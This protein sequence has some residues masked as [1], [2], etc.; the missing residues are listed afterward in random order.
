MLQRYWAILKNYLHV[1]FGEMNYRPPAWSTRFAR[2]FGQTRMGLWLKS[3]CE[4]IKT[5]PRLSARYGAIGLVIAAILGYGVYRGV[6][7]YQSRPKPDY[8]KVTLQ[9]PGNYDLENK[10]SLPL[11]I[12]FSQS[13][14]PLDSVDKSPAEHIELSPKVEGK[15]RWVSDRQIEFTPASTDDPKSHWVAG[16]KY[17]VTLKKKLVAKHILLE[18]FDY[19]F[20]A[21]EMKAY[22]NKQEFYQ[23][24]RDPKIKRALVNFSYNYPL[25]TEDFKKR[26]TMT[27]QTKDASVLGASAK[28]V[29]F[30][31]TFNKYQ[32]EAYLQSDPIAIPKEDSEV[33]VVVEKGVRDFRGG[34]PT[35]EKLSSIV[36]IPGMFNYFRFE[37]PQITFARNERYE[38]EQ[39]LVLNSKADIASENVAKVLE[40]FVLPRN[41]PSDKDKKRRH[42]FRST[43]E[44]TPEVRGLMKPLAFTLIPTETPT[45]T[46]HSFKTNAAAGQ[47]IYLKI[48]K[49][50]KSF[51]GYELAQDFEAVVNVPSYP[52]ELLIMSQGSLLS[53]SG[54]KKIPLLSRNVSKVDFKVSRILPDQLNQLIVQVYPSSNDFSHP[55]FGYFSDD[56]L[57]EK[58]TETREI[59]IDKPMAT[60]YFSFDLQSYLNRGSQAGRR[61][62]FYLSA[63]EHKGS[64]RDERLILLTDL[65][66]VVKET[67]NNTNDVFV[68]NIHSGHAVAG[69]SVE[70]LGANGIPVMEAR[71][72]ADGRASFPDLRDFKNEKRPIAF[73]V[74]N[75]SDYSFLPYQMASRQLNFSNF[76]TG[77]IYESGQSGTLN[78]FLFSDRGIYRPGDTVNFGM[79]VRG[80]NWKNTFKDVPVTWSVTDARGTEILREKIK[81]NSSD[82]MALKFDTKDFSPTGT[83]DV[84]VFITKKNEAD[85]QIGSLNVRVEEFLPDRMRISTHL[86]QERLDGWVNPKDLKARVNLQNLF[87]TPAENRLVKATLDLSTSSPGFRS[88]R[89]YSFGELN[90]ENKNFSEPLEGLKTDAKGN[91]EFDLN[92]QRFDAVM[93]RLKFEAEGFEAEGGRGVSATAGALVSPLPYLIGYRR[94]SDLTYLNKNSKHAIHLIA[95]NPELKKIAIDDVKLE[96]IERRYVSSLTKQYDGTYKYQS[97]VKE[98]PVETKPLKITAGG[99]DFELPTDKAGD[100]T[101]SLKN[102]EGVVLNKI[103]FTVT[104]EGNLSRSLEKNAELG[105]VLNKKDYKPGEEI[106]MQIKAPYSG[107]GLITIERDR[108]FTHKWFKTSTSATV[109]RIRIPEGVEGN[110]FVN[111]TFLRAIDSKEIFMSPLSYAVQPFS[112][113]LDSHRVN[114][115]LETKDLVKPGNKLR[116]TYSADKPTKIIVYGVNEGILQV[117]GYKLPDPLTY[118][119]QRR[120]LQVKTFQLL[121]LLLPEYSVLQSLSAPGGDSYGAM[122]AENLNPFKRKTD[123]PVVFW[124]GVVNAGPEARHYD[125]EVPDYFNG[126]I[127]VMAVAANNAIFGSTDKQV[128]VRGDFILSPNVPAFV[129]PGDEFEV[130]TGISNQAEKSGPDAKIKIE[131]VKSE[132]FEVLGENVQTAAVAEGHEGSVKFRLKAKTKLGS[133]KVLLRASLG[134]KSAKAQVEFS[135]RPATPYIS[136]MVAG[137]AEKSSFDIKVERQLL[138]EFRK[139]QAGLSPVPA[140]LIPSLKTFLDDFNYACTEQA[141]SKAMPYV[142]LKARPEFKVDVKTAADSFAS[143]ITLLRTRQTGNGGFGLYLPDQDSIEASLYALHLFLEAKERGFSV[144]EDMLEKA[145]TFA[146]ST[147]VRNTKTIFDI[148]QFAY[149]VYLRARAGRVPGSDVSFIH[150]ALEKNFKDVWKSD[151]AAAYLAATYK[152]VK[153]DDQGAKVFSG[154]SVGED[155][156]PNYGYFYDSL[157]RDTTV[158]YL[159]ARHFPEQ[160]KKFVTNEA[161]AKVLRPLVRGQY[162][163]YSAAHALLT[164]DQLVRNA[165]QAEILNQI[166][167][168]EVQAGGKRVALTMPNLLTPADFSGDAEKIA[169][170]ASSSTPMF[171]VHLQNG[172]D[173]ELPKTEL[174]KNMEITRE[175]LDGKGNVVNKAKV[176]EELT[177]RLRVRAL[178][179]RTYDNIVLVDLLPG[180]F[181]PVL[182]KIAMGGSSEPE[183]APESYTPEPES[184]FFEEPEAPP[185]EEGAMNLLDLILPRAW[186][187]DAVKAALNDLSPHY[188]D[189]REDRMVVYGSISAEAR[190]FRYKI[191]AVAQGQFVVPPPF[192]ESMYDK[193]LMYRGL[194]PSFTIEAP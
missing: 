145:L 117:A 69:A 3:R 154:L 55:N 60:Q 135:I 44:I 25:D 79:I 129:A 126:T 131:L 171:Y 59:K 118:F 29:P 61:G 136:T 123:K 160:L 161:M 130:S 150:Q 134:E 30:T 58:F 63:T 41:L 162:N 184:D 174:R 142:I 71:T 50:I 97:V 8:A 98:V 170:Q 86:S 33:K 81:V 159:A 53:L 110:A 190:E 132:E 64:S 19:D 96:L 10:K 139:Q 67:V 77:G 88:L 43:S 108:V 89:E 73:V 49:G 54:D 112:V 99:A 9:R 93:Y 125:Y 115:K 164:L 80:R 128:L 181:E 124:S 13:V 122:L 16:E 102:A 121:D 51:G 52:K 23:D 22:I 109:E 114:I 56:T 127:K 119:F 26:L 74:K 75:G 47:Y 35:P 179:Q 21:R 182:E 158:I 94:D 24:P 6:L 168:E 175:Y 17:T 70:V 46:M 183:D 7:W 141:I 38:P 106:E 189:R 177:V 32:N 20:Q 45:S 156:E 173:R 166:K 68:Q 149:A 4:W 107:A 155:V 72:G 137:L 65:G 85:Q 84:R 169:Y 185:S 48:A 120:A 2:W 28:S 113:S 78:A 66:V 140:I 157:S 186:A 37:T 144:P 42:R 14:A 147:Y 36:D 27:L 116:V 194:S 18:K 90:P 57:A 91:A 138:P 165:S 153:Q 103:P 148:R 152:I 100:F 34:N 11:N 143:L 104:G 95:V 40:A 5:N 188:V 163:T 82:M 167:I 172:F 92:L 83:Y 101:L 176:G 133:A 39:V 62:L 111:V 87:G 191:K 151:L 192:G 187:E 31:V 193:S 15:W 178:D 76:D 180:G 1:I 146:E 105:L 12:Y